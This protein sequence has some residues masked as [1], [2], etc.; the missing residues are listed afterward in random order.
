MDLD[1]IIK[2]QGE[3]YAAGLLEMKDIDDYVANRTS[4]MEAEAAEAAKK[5]TKKKA[6]KASKKS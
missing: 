1:T 4:E 3:A 5:T 2:L 6:K